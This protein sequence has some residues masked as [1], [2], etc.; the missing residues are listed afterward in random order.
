MNALPQFGRGRWNHF[1]VFAKLKSRVYFGYYCTGLYLIL[2][3]SKNKGTRG[4]IGRTV[5]WDRKTCTKVRLGHCTLTL[6]LFLLFSR[7]LF[8]FSNRCFSP[9]S[10]YFSFNSH[11]SPRFLVAEDYIEDKCAN[12]DYKTRRVGEASK[13]EAR[14]PVSFTIL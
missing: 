7:C 14:A 3:E 9:A 10:A 12:Q 6:A 2:R 5:L 11:R 13:P 8:N 4:A 1:R